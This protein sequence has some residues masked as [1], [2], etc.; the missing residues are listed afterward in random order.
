MNIWQG[1]FGRDYTM[2]NN[3]TP[4]E[5]NDLYRKLY[6]VSRTQIN[7][8]FLGDLD[9]SLRI[10]EVGANVGVQLALLQA[11]GFTNL[12]GVELQWY[13]VELAQQNTRHI[14]IL[15]GTAFDLPF[16][17]GFFDLVFTS[18]VLIHI[19]PDDMAQAMQEIYRCSRR[20]IWGLEYWNAKYI[21]VPYRE[22]ERLLWKGDFAAI[23]REH[24]P[25]LRL[26]KETHYSYIEHNHLIDTVFLLEKG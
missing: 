5:M 17:D 18:G 24:F 19:A 25:T 23:Y 10:L 26:L 4:D 7:Q 15:Q 2:R 6:G 20:Y 14:N 3:Y 11:A 16:K 8:E 1:K 21:E 12:Y 9:R 13:A 22:H